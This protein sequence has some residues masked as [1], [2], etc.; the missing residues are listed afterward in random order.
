MKVK[1]CYR[2]GAEHHNDDYEHCSHECWH[3]DNIGQYKKTVLLAINE[4]KEPTLEK[5]KQRL[6]FCGFNINQ[7][8]SNPTVGRW[9]RAIENRLNEKAASE[10]EIKKAA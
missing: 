6:K 8:C 3:R 9:E 7:D 1:N 4:V 10:V 5:V 2:C